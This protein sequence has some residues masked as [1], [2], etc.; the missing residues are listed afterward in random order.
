MEISEKVET[1]NKQLVDEFGR[2]ISTGDAIWRVVWSEDQFEKR[3]GTYDDFTKSGIYI[4]TVTEVR[5]VPKYRQWIQKKYV[6][7]RLV[8]VPT[9]TEEILTKTSYEPIYVFEDNKHNYLPPR[10]DAAK[11]VIELIYAAQGKPIR[12]EVEDDPNDP[13]V[14]EKRIMKLQQ[15]LFGNDT[16]IG[17]ALTYGSGISLAG[18]QKNG[19]PV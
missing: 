16:K 9:G 4:R 19:N 15:E 11:F 5:L 6:L 3:F 12:I 13:Q 7:E 1:I 14:R 17:D 10:F 8:I 2:D 18:A